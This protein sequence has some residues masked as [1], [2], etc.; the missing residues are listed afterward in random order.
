MAGR[1][2]GGSGLRKRGQCCRWAGAGGG[3]R[4]VPGSAGYRGGGALH[5]QDL[6]LRG[7]PALFPPRMVP[8]ALPSPF[9]L[10][11][12][13]SLSVAAPVASFPPALGSL[14]CPWSTAPLC[15]LLPALLS[16]PF[17]V[18]FPPPPPP[19]PLPLPCTCPPRRRLPPSLFCPASPL[20]S[21]R[22]L[23]LVP[24]DRRP[25]GGPLRGLRDLRPLCAR[26]GPRDVAGVSA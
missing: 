13:S 11:A 7:R 3:G 20:L 8:F 19:L 5:H 21:L 2:G 10:P 6:R 23:R 4:G 12:A 14:P 9:R 24:R 25:L 26:I 18:P 16:V 22:A 15:S 17:T 1:I